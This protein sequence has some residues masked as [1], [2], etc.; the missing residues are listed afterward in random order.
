[1]NHFN[2]FWMIVPQLPPAID[3]VG[4][5]ALRI[6]SQLHQEFGINTYFLIG[7]P[8]WQGSTDVE[9]FAA[10]AVGDRTFQAL[11]TSLSHQSI[12]TVIL[13]YVTYGYARKGYP[14]WL[15]EGLEQWKASVPNARLITMFH[16]LYQHGPPWRRNFWI[17]PSQKRLVRRLAILSDRCITSIQEYADTLYVLS[18]GKHS[19]IPTLPI[20][21]N[22]AEPSTVL[23]LAKRQKRLVVFG[24]SSSRQGVY[25]HSSKELSY[26]CQQLGISEILDIGP[27]I[28][29]ELTSINQV[30]IR[31]LGP[32]SAELVSDLL[33]NSL[34]GFLRYEPHRLAKSGIFAAYCAH[35]L[36]PITVQPNSP[37]PVDGLVSGTHYCN[38]HS[39]PPNSLLE[40]QIIADNAFGWYQKHTLAK[41]TNQLIHYLTEVAVL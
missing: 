31:V 3:G 32:Q 20:F 1:M 39:P 5:Y 21:S 16:E 25:S 14:D 2:G 33:A 12:S 18:Q 15:V 22:V 9:G 13:H 8:D 35:G 6:A 19:T 27:P 28:G 24:Q 23:P 11:L 7:D 29:V 41:H 10:N 34:A 36:L 37:I 38:P 40:Q 17:T 30:P 4:D 26:I